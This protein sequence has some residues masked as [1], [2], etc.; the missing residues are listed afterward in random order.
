MR[1]VAA[2]DKRAEIF[3]EIFHR[4]QTFLRD[5]VISPRRTRP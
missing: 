4:D 3:R 5:V 1:D 2:I